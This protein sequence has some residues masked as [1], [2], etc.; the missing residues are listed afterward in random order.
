MKIKEV[1]G[2]LQESLME[3][4]DLKTRYRL[5]LE[6]KANK[7]QELESQLKEHEDKNNQRN[8]EN[9]SLLE[10]EVDGMECRK[11]E[12][13]NVTSTKSSKNGEVDE[14]GA[15]LLLSSLQRELICPLCKDLLLD[16]VVVPCSHAFCF[17]CW[18]GYC[19]QT[20]GNTRGGNS[21]NNPKCPVCT[22]QFGIQGTTLKSN[23]SHRSMHIDNVVTALMDYG[24]AGE[25]QSRKWDLRVKKAEA[26][27]LKLGLQEVLSTQKGEPNQSPQKPHLP[28]T[29]RKSSQADN[30]KQQQ[31]RR[32]SSS[33][34]SAFCEGCNE[35]GHSFEV[36]PHRSDSALEERSDS[37][38]EDEED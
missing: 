25:S 38:S 23:H 4:S 9:Q 8:L 13:Q 26:K 30:D 27:V 16:A 7:I 11:N 37:S 5:D 1:E 21:T 18:H 6:K 24:S 35:Q 20:H 34:M 3:L 36:C 32:R 22:Q 28:A 29:P 15:Q 14:N 17:L 10:G 33:G 19:S 31:V 2:Q 12:P